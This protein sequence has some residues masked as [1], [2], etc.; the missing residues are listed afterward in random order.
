MNTA[1]PNPDSGE[2]NRRSPRHGRG[3]SSQGRQIINM[4]NAGVKQVVIAA[5]LGVSL[6]SIKQCLRRHRRRSNIQGT[7]NANESFITEPGVLHL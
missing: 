7:D 5:K 2:N 4:R 6:G 3:P 1:T